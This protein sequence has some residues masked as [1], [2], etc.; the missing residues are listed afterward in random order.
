MPHALVTYRN[1]WL[2]Q[3]PAHRPKQLWEYSDGSRGQPLVARLRDRI[4]SSPPPVVQRGMSRAVKRASEMPA[5]PLPAR[6]WPRRMANY[7]VAA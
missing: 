6:A 3:S 1:F 5:P 4:F 2:D 7:A